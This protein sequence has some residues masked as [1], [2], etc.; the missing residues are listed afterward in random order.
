MPSSPGTPRSSGS[1]L[2][3]R[4]VFGSGPAAAGQLHMR[5]N[6]RCRSVRSAQ[7]GRS[8]RDRRVTGNLSPVGPNALDSRNGSRP[9]Q[10]AAKSPSEDARVA[11]AET[12]VADVSQ[13]LAYHRSGSAY[14]YL[15]VDSMTGKL[16]IADHPVATAR[17]GRTRL[18][19]SFNPLLSAR[20]YLAGD[21]RRRQRHGAMEHRSLTM[22]AFS[23][24]AL[25]AFSI[26]LALR[27]T[28]V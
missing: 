12:A 18:I 15:A 9:K 3:F 13:R 14:R 10:G 24:S 27:P 16:S 20:V 2:L 26:Q 23:M 22:S 17:N 8:L 28:L 4:R 19:P 6:I 7:V 1:D 25:P 5:V 11:P 21:S